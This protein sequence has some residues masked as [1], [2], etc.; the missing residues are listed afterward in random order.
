[1]RVGQNIE[2]LIPYVPGKPVEELEREM[3]IKNAV[4]LASNENPLGPSPKGIAM[5]KRYIKQ[6]HRYPEGG[7]YYLSEKLSKNLGVKPENILFG[8]GSNEVLE[9]IG[10]TFYEHGDEIVFSQY[11]FIVYKLVAQALGAVYHEV[12]ANNLGHDLYNMLNYIHPK[13]KIVYLANP[14]NPTGTM[15][16]KK[17][18][19]DFMDKVPQTTLVVLDEA[20]SEY[21]DDKDYP[22]GLTFLKKYKNL[23]IVRTF[24]KIYGLAGLRI[25]YAVGDEKLISYMNRVREPFNVNTLA[26]FAALGALDDKEHIEK[27]K[28]I[29]QEGFKYLYEELDKI[30]I[31]YIKSYGNFI[32][33][34]TPMK[35]VDF[36]NLLLKEGVI[37]RP[38]AGYGL[39]DFVRVTVGT[40][41]ENKKFIIATKKV[42]KKT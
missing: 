33:I 30:G 14:N 34:K 7:C 28:K 42:L 20:Y 13:T 40:Q 1:M 16:T 21:V 15:F 23:I 5:M 10:R 31:E 39:I 38:V 25:G 2:R 26:Q 18:F 35:G 41:T 11:A 3:G 9:I 27:T 36:Y 12:P 29:T 22:D 19:R 8:N 17:E 4:K 6:L 32:L 37:V 24:S